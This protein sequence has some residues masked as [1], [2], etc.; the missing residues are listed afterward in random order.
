[1]FV[2]KNNVT[3]LTAKLVNINEDRVYNTGSK[4]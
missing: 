2:L 4:L 3:L 1:M